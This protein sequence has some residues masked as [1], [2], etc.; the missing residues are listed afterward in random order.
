MRSGVGFRLRFILYKFVCLRVFEKKYIYIVYMYKYF[1]ISD[2][3]WSI[4][5]GFWVF[6]LLVLFVF[7]SLCIMWFVL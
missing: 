4:V 5:L 3:K 1:L 6:V 2:I 7:V